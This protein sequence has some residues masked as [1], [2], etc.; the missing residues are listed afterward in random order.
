[1]IHHEVQV[2]I[3]SALMDIHDLSVEDIFT[4]SQG[5]LG[6]KFRI[7]ENYLSFAGFLNFSDFPVGLGDLHHFHNF[8][9]L[10]ET[11]EFLR[12]PVHGFGDHVALQRLQEGVLDAV[13]VGLDEDLLD[14][15]IVEIL[16]LRDGQELLNERESLFLALVHDVLDLAAP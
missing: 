3:H 8:A 4:L 9:F 14:H 12:E 1:M 11:N 10:L 6:L 2:I 16:N 7:S 15:L 13:V 5:L